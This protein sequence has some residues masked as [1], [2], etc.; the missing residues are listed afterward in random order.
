MKE[1]INVGDFYEDCAYHPV[2]CTYAD[3]DCVEGI[4]LI[5]GVSKGCSVHACAPKKISFKQAIKLKFKGPSKKRK[6]HIK[7]LN[8]AGWCIKVWWE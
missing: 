4:S 5:D 6:E 3:D 8:E 7:A 1:K 2:L